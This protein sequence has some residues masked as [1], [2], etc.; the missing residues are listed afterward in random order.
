MFSSLHLTTAITRHVVATSS[1]RN[2]CNEWRN[3]LSSSCIHKRSFQAAA[4]TSASSELLKTSYPIHLRYCDDMTAV[5][6]MLTTSC[7][8]LDSRFSRKYSNDTKD[9]ESPINDE[10][11]NNTTTAASAMNQRAAG[12][13]LTQL[14]TVPNILTL[15]RIAA[16]PYLSYLLITHHHTKQ[17][18]NDVVAG[19]DT[20]SA[21]AT[22]AETIATHMDPSSIPLYA[23][24]L[25][26]FMGFTDFLDGY[27]ARKFPSS[28]TVLGTYLDPFADKVFISA[29]SLT[30]WY[31]ETLPGALVSLWI[32]RDVG[33][34]FSVYYLVKQET[35]KKIGSGNTY[36]VMDPQNTPLKVEA[37]LLSKI[38]TSLQIGLIALG[39]AGE[40]PA[41]NIDADLMTSLCWITAG[42]TVGS[43]I[44]YFGGSA[45]RKSGNK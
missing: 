32:A 14:T 11:K 28:S 18:S 41:V 17:T 2:Y 22:A 16:T 40:V 29:L 34:V 20:S 26:L 42:T 36:A 12:A 13:I 24:S 8:L 38:N 9:T 15:S 31:T 10:N 27:I 3:L 44:G 5:R 19:I 37:S 7:V 21:T 43:T 35:L 4:S 23:L 30:L 25:F 45:F 1:R 33:I 6:R 39:I